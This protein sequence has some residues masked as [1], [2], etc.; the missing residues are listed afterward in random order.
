MNSAQIVMISSGSSP[1]ELKYQISVS[2]EIAAAE[3]FS[4]CPPGSF[5]AAEVTFPASFP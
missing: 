1:P 3:A 5:L 4:T 2:T